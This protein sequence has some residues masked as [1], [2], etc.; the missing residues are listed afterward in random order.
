MCV[1]VRACVSV[2]ACVCVKVWQAH[3]HTRTQGLQGK[4]RPWSVRE[5]LVLA[6]VVH[7]IKAAHAR[8]KLGQLGILFWIQ[9]V[10]H[11]CIHVCVCVYACFT[12]APPNT[13]GQSTNLEDR[14]EEIVENL[15]KVLHQPGRSVH[16]ADDTHRHRHT[17][18]QTHRHTDTQT[19]KTKRHKQRPV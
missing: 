6:L 7:G 9:R 2:R 3:T 16:V 13:H 11:A 10:L 8:Q 19:Y 18:T 17:D 5:A 15:C 1:C 12:P 4:D 14:A